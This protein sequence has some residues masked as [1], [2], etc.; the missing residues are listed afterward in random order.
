MLYNLQRVGL[1]AFVAV[2]A[3]TLLLSAAV[4][5]ASAA[6]PLKTLKITAKAAKDPIVRGNTETIIITV[7]DSA[8][9]PVK[10]ASISVKV[11]YASKGTVKSF[12]GKTNANGVYSFSWQIGGN[13]NP[14]TFTVDGKVTKT[15]YTAGTVKLSFEVIA[16]K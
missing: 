10:D 8:G 16:K 15:G 1:V 13:S 11:M 6:T 2:L 9:K 7:K 14:G 12:T 5:N 4:Q 3:A